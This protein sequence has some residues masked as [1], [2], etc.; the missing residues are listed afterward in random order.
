MDV[1]ELFT[2]ICDRIPDAMARHK[3][4]GVALGIVCEG[5]EFIKGF[6]VTNIRHP[7]PVDE[8]TLF[9]IGSTTKTFT[10]TAVMRL[11]E[12]GKL[13]LD[14]PILTYLP[15]FKMRDPEVT[16][17]VTMRHL[18]THTGGWEGDFFPD[19]GNGDD[20]LA[21]YV[22]LMA[23]LPQLT[24]LGTILSYNNAA[25]SL[26]GRVVEVVTGKTYEVA[27]NEL[28]LRPLG[29]KHS[30]LFP[31][32]VMTH[33]Y[34]VGHATLGDRTVVLRPWQVIRA[35][36][37]AGGIAASMKDQL[38]YAR[39]HLGDGTAEDGLRILTP[40]SIAMMQTPGNARML[41]I[42][43]GLAWMTRDIGGLRRV[44][45]GG[46]TYGQI[47]AFTMTPA[48][49]FGLALATNSMNGGL[50]NL[51]VTKGLVAKFLGNDEPEPAEI[52]MTPS[53]LAE[54]SG[55]YTRTMGEDIEI[56]TEADK[57]MMQLYPKGGFPTADT[58]PAPTP[59][60]F[61]VGLIDEDRIAMVEPAFKDIRGEFIRNPDGSIAW[62]RWGSRIHART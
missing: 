32:D 48:R 43:M 19:T 35:C 26:A 39:F 58:P 2:G 17:R 3:V 28:V 31:T 61:R 38:R 57:L 9:Q 11:V 42:K 49:K 52:P 47:S 55:R 41:D 53:Q 45:H 23:D 25:F 24:P 8:K 20:A 44:F 18:L 54:Y 1:E 27:L 46:G 56:K 62:L 15:D 34:A 51:E 13:A 50:L 60:P 6:G 21:R 22:K 29:L 40:E 33:S 12:A 4:P 36:A 7:L 5:R 14:E 16:A 10:A 37:S 30:F 59:R